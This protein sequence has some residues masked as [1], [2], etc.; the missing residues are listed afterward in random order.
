M[1]VVKRVFCRL[2]DVMFIAPTSTIPNRLARL[3]KPIAVMHPRHLG[4]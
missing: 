2:S 4:P 1:T 3:Q